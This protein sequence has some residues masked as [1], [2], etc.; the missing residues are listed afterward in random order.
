MPTK[1]SNHTRRRVI[2]ERVCIHCGYSWRYKKCKVVRCPV[3]RKYQ[4]DVS[5]SLKSVKKNKKKK[6]ELKT[7]ANAITNNFLEMLKKDLTKEP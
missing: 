3:C 7:S 2:T 4:K 6:E 1:Q 5:P